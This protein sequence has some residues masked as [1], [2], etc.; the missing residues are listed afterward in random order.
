MGFGVRK[1]REAAIQAA[2]LRYLNGL[3]GCRAENNHGNGWQGAGR[4][5]IYGCYRGRMIVIEVKRP[6]EQPTKLQMHRLEQWAAAGAVA[7]VAVS[8]EDVKQAIGSL[9]GVMAKERGIGG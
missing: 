9:E 7:I 5:D 1:P 2:I 8:V 6:G 3:P 4:P